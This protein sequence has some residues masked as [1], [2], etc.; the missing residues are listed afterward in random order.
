MSSAAVVIDAL[1]VKITPFQK[2]GKT[3]WTECMRMNVTNVC[4]LFRTV[5]T[6][7]HYAF[8]CCCCFVVSISDPFS[9]TYITK[10]RLNN[11]DPAKPHFY[12]VKL[13]FT[14]VYIIFLILLK[15]KD[16]GY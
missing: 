2:G 8:C 14:G 4:I 3:I 5:E 12:I 16:C 15:N 1:R 13:G 7:E 11:F 9:P 10:T 6:K